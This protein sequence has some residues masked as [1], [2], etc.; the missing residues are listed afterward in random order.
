M[1]QKIQEEVHKEVNIE[2][3]MAKKYTERQGG[4]VVSYS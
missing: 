1:K 3:V 2:Q 4:C